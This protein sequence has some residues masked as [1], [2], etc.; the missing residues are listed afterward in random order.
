MHSIDGNDY[1]T[2]FV[3]IFA[4]SDPIKRIM[5]RAAFNRIKH[6]ECVIYPMKCADVLANGRHVG[7]I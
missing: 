7:Y 4:L 6:S 3:S 5:F 1:Y 2:F